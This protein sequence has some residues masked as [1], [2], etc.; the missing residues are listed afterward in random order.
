[1]NRKKQKKKYRKLNEMYEIMKVKGKG[2][3]I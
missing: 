2:K 3:T 1:M